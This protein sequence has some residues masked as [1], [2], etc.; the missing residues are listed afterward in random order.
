MME[1]NRNLVD[2]YRKLN[3]SYKRKLIFH[4]GGDKGAGF[5]SELNT[6]L[7]SVLFALKYKY[8]FVLYSKDCHFAFG[9]GWGEFFH[10]FCPEYDNDYIGKK[11]GRTYLGY[12]NRR[13]FLYKLLS[14]NLIENDIY[15]LCRSAWFE[16][17][18]FDIPELAIKGDIRDALKVVISIVYR[19]NE[20]YQ[21]QIED[22]MEKLNLPHD[23][24]C[25]HIRG[26]DKVK[27]RDLI[28][29][30]NYMDRAEDMTA[31]RNV[32]LFTDDYRILKILEANNPQWNFFTSTSEHEVG[33][34]AYEYLKEPEQNIRHSFIELFASIEIAVKSELF[35]GT[36]SSNIGLFIGML[37]DDSKFVGMDFDRW[38]IL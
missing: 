36:Y 1:K 19:F 11:I 14:G 4:I 18:M 16:Q 7:L 34:D 24:I 3:E 12:G 28:E 30:Q 8:Q 22:Y 21:Q 13:L 25:M 29:P 32:F 37:L 38:M 15:G 31:C 5:Y 26:G 6:L 33:H 27:E 9:N 35:I 20:I 10:Q 2:I 23:F 17:E